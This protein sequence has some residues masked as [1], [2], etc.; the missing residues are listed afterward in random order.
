VALLEELRNFLV[1]ERGFE[2]SQ[3]V[4][5]TVEIADG[6]SGTFAEGL[7]PQLPTSAFPM[8]SFS[9]RNFGWISSREMRRPLT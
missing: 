7:A 2:G 3:L 4:H 9:M 5:A 1:A 8:R 6:E